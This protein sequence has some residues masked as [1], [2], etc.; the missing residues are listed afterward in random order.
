MQ[1][2]MKAQTDY[3]SF[4]SIQVVSQG[5]LYGGK[6]CAALDRQ[7]PRDLFDI[8]YLLE[9]GGITPEIKTGFLLCLL[10][11]DRHIHKI[12]KSNFQDQR[13]VL[14]NQF[15]G[16]TRELFSYDEFETVRDALVENV[17]TMLTKKDKQF[18]LGFKNVT[19]D[20][21]IHD[22]ERFP[23]VQWKLQNLRKLKKANTEKHQLLLKNLAEKLG[24]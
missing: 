12:I 4:C 17:N 18:I 13:Q 24:E 10:S 11:S 3:D 1:L 23:A 8:K 19:P 9:E 16:M 22:F 14:D 7:H 21:S 2:C 5:Q 15:V 20:W 6:I